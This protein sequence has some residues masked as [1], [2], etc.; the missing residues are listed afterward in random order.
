[1]FICK[2]RQHKIVKLKPEGLSTNFD[3]SITVERTMEKLHC[4]EIKHH[5]NMYKHLKHSWLLS[6]KCQKKSSD[7]R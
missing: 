1:M 4:N 7:L 6:I 5:K 3:E 2:K